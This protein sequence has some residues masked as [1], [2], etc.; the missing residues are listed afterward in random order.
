M[1][2]YETHHLLWVRAAPGVL[3]QEGL[4][5]S[6][7]LGE[8]WPKKSVFPSSCAVTSAVNKGT[9]V[10]SR[11]LGLPLLQRTAK[12]PQCETL[13]WGNL[14]SVEAP[15]A[16]GFQN[17]EPSPHPWNCFYKV[18]AR[19]TLLRRTLPQW[20]HAGGK[21][22]IQLHIQ[23]SSV[24]PACCKPVTN[25]FL[26]T[27]K[28]LALEWSARGSPRLAQLC[29]LPAALGSPAQALSCSAPRCRS[30]LDC[31]KTLPSTV[32]YFMFSCIWNDA[33]ASWRYGRGADKKIWMLG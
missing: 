20:T 11:G 26:S 12:A 31:T 28:M 30:S 9:I 33:V 19:T 18:A 14:S 22:Y 5:G 7:L 29:P 25:V 2:I 27:Q 10:L 6:G 3:C 15:T 4:G 21:N 32:G 24:V 17:R 16:V 1:F 23:P 13:A 8:M